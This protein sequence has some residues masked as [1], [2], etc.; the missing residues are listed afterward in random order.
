M[1]SKLISHIL[2]RCQCTIRYLSDSTGIDYGIIY[3]MLNDNRTPT[4]W[5][6]KQLNIFLQEHTDWK[7]SYINMR[8]QKAGEEIGDIKGNSKG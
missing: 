3:R 8:L 1:I 6:S 4:E 2:Y 5:E 7:Q